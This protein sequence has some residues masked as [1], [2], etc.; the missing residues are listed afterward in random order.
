MHALAEKAQAGSLT[1]AERAELDSY[2]RIGCLLGML[3]SKA[4]ISLNRA[5]RS[6]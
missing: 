4:R 2:E 1:G 5:S 3:Q 6:E